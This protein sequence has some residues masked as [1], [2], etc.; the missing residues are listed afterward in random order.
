M[1]EPMKSHTLRYWLQEAD[2]QYGGQVLIKNIEPGTV[3]YMVRGIKGPFIVGPKGRRVNRTI[4]LQ[5]L[6]RYGEDGQYRHKDQRTGLRSDTWD[7]MDPEERERVWGKV[8]HNLHFHENYLIHVV[9]SD[10]SEE[11]E[12]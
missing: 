2:A 7:A 5:L 9:D 6:Q 1:S 11:E 8:S 10:D 4:A 3:E 12:D